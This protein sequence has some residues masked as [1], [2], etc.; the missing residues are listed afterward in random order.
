VK[1]DQELLDWLET[2]TKKSWTGISFDWTESYEDDPAGFRFMRWHFLGER[3][4]TLREAIELA[5]KKEGSFS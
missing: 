3:A 2:Q 1:T 4:K 5:M